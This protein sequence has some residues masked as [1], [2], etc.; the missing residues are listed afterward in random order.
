MK[1]VFDTNV[2]ISAT[3]WDNSV[4]H[5]LLIKLIEMDKEIIISFDIL[6]EYKKVLIRDFKYN[7]NEINDI[8]AGLSEAFKIIGPNI[9]IDVVKDDIDDNKILECAISSNAEFILTYDRHLLNIKKYKSIRIVKPEEFLK[10]F[11][12]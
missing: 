1:I 10:L 7:L 2:L 3:L 8:F 11:K 4:C 6:N 12:D 9:K 5:K